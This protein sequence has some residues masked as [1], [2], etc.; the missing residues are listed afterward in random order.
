[1][2][3]VT[4]EEAAAIH[5]NY[6][7]ILDKE[8]HHD[9]EIIRDDHGTIRWKQV[10]TVC[11]IIDK[12]I[13]NDLVVLFRFMGINKNSEEWRKL[14]RQMG[15]SLSGYW[16]IFYWEMNNEDADDYN[17]NLVKIDPG[18][19]RA[20]NESEVKAWIDNLYMLGG[21]RGT[22]KGDQ[23]YKDKAIKRILDMFT[24]FD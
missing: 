6:K 5:E 16:E 14:Y 20:Q 11:A 24:K 19:L 10:D 17:P 3:T 13:L 21:S 18:A 12:G 2:E 8:S 1:M 7:E 9:H 15:Y 22:I 4:R 23:A